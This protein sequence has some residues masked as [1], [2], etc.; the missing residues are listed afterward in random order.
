MTSLHRRHTTDTTTVLPVTLKY[1]DETG[2]LAV[3]DLTGLV[4]KFKMKNMATNQVIVDETTT[5]VT[6]TDAVAGEAQYDFSSD[7]VL[8]PG[9]YKAWFVVYDGAESDHYPPDTEGLKIYIDSDLRTAEEAYDIS[10]KLRNASPFPEELIIGDS[11]T[12]AVGR[13]IRIYVVDELGD[14]ISSVGTLDFADATVSFTFARDR[15]PTPITGSTAVFTDG[16]TPY[17][18]ISIPATVTSQAKAEYSYI[19]TVKFTW[20]SPA[21]VYSFKTE[22]FVFTE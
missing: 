3:R 15:D 16:A 2:T 22:A 10:I 6:V 9:I 4:V 21:A 13:A 11:Y 5:G 17:V 19:G 18:D 14:P 1:P 8:I 20:A 12:T 7:E